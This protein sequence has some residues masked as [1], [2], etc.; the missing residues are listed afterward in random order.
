MDQ[1]VSIIQTHVASVAVGPSAARGRGRSGVVERARR[2]LGVLPLSALGTSNQDHFRDELDRATRKLTAALPE[3]ARC[4]G[5]SRK[6]LNI[7]LRDA[8]YN[9]Y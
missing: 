8:L 4:W 2:F 6:L 9:H 7:F 3:P 5:L 1:I